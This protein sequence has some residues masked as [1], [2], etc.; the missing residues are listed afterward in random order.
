MLQ[1]ARDN[2]NMPFLKRGMHCD[3][4]G[5]FAHLTS[6]NSTHLRVRFDGNKFTSNVH[7]WWQMTYYAADGSVI[8][9]YKQAK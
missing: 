9:D 2:R 8:A 4:D 7:P 1:E 6:G 5:R 3:C